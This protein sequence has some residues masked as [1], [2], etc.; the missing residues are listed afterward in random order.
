MSV[1]WR[2]A[3]ALLAA[4]TVWAA[5]P[6]GDDVAFL[7]KH[8]QVIVLAAADGQAQVAV[9]PAWQG[10]VMTSTDGGAAGASYGWINREHIASRKLVKHMNPFGGEDRFWMG[11]E[12]GQFAIFFGK[13]DPFDREHW[14]TPAAIDSEPFDVV[15]QS[16]DAVRFAR[17]FAVTNWSG[18]RFDVG[19]SREI[20]L[21]GAAPLWKHLGVAAASGVSAVGFESV[22]RV[23]NHG[24]AAWTERTGLLSI[25]ILGMFGASPEMT[26][27]I[28]IRE[29]AGPRV[30]DDYFGKVPAARLVSEPRT[31]F[32]RADGRYRSKIGVGPARAMPVMGSYDPK[33]GVLTIVQYTL[34]AGASR[35]VN[36]QWKRQ[37]QPFAGDVINSY[38][39][40]GQMG[41]FYELESSSPAAALVPGGTQEHV[42]RT[43]HL[44]GSA[45]AL[46]PVARAVL[47]VGLERV[48]TALGK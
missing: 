12:G 48:R 11:P 17:R 6:F 36:S 35:Y 23:T 14:Q 37:E 24:A 32:F 16:K 1:A 47:G 4:S 41:N 43:I 29:G 8:T 45:A 42:H 40:D 44:K 22:N 10:R 18:S 2:W 26:V 15:S 20:R 38:S 3:V 5:A 13:G 46:D 30:T 19:V 27:V 25:W 7:R 33:A 21:L 9:V 28:P 34:P 31:L 39:D